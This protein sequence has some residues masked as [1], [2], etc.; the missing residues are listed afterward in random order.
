MGQLPSADQ[1]DQ[2]QRIAPLRVVGHHQF[3]AFEQGREDVDQRRIEAQRRELQ[4]ST[5]CLQLHVIGIPH[6]EVRKIGLTEQNTLRMPGGA[7][8]VERH[9]RCVEFRAAA[10]QRV[11]EICLG[12]VD[13]T[14][15]QPRHCCAQW[16]H[17][18]M[19]QQHCTGVLQNVLLALQWM[20]RFQRQIHRAAAEDC[21]N[22]G[23]QRRAFR[24]AD[25]HHPRLRML[26][27]QGLQT[28]LD[29]ATV[30]VQLPIADRLFGEV[31]RR[32]FG[33]P[34]QAL[35]QALDHW[36]LRLLQQRRIGRVIEAM[37]VRQAVEK[38]QVFHPLEIRRRHRYGPLKIFRIARDAAD[39]QR[40]FVHHL[41]QHPLP[42]GLT[43]AGR[44]IG[45]RHAAD[46]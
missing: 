13:T 33:M 44:L 38:Q 24:Q 30:G 25:A 28:L 40:H 5:F 41:R 3:G 34:D 22:R 14:D 37:D 18:I 26:L 10:H 15:I 36:E 2:L 6:G 29:R 46:Q 23:E 12:A 35:L 43:V 17:A 8:G 19:Q 42:Q 7:R 16:M 4:D 39:Q 1:R 20:A 32:S 45:N 31:Q 21:Q 9:A 11:A 27:E